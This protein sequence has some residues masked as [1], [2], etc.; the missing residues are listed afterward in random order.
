MYICD[1]L[2]SKTPDLV[3]SAE[4]QQFARMLVRGRYRISRWGDGVVGLNDGEMGRLVGF[5]AF[6]HA[7]SD[8]HSDGEEVG[9]HRW[10]EC[11]RGGDAVSSLLSRTRSRLGL[12]GGVARVDAK[13]GGNGLL[14]V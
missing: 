6:R 2:F 1:G 12:G 7:L 14:L 3:Q 4:G 11:V 9:L 5:V 10:R 8:S 13:E